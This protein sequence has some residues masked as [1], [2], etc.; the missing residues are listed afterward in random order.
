[1]G[2]CYRGGEEA[3]ERVC[4]PLLRYAVEFD[5]VLVITALSRIGAWRLQPGSRCQMRPQTGQFAGQPCGAQ[6]S[7][8]GDHCTQCRAGQG[9]VRLHN[10]ARRALAAEMRSDGLVALEE[11]TAPS[12]T[13]RDASG[14]AIDGIAD[15]AVRAPW[16]AQHVFLDLTFVT[17]SSVKHRAST[18]QAAI[19]AAAAHK[20]QRYQGCMVPI[21]F[22]DK[23]RPDIAAVEALYALASAAATP[24]SATPGRMLNRWL[25]SM[26]VAR[27]AALAGF[28]GACFVYSFST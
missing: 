12:L 25:R 27:S 24:E 21:A 2:D 20:R 13:Q 16:S 5:D 8:L 10:S 15:I 1:M 23:G 7:E 4:R 18:V 3:T 28:L 17:T 19:R 11:F 22:S 14:K 6:L 26:E 9:R